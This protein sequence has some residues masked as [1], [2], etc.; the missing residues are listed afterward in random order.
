[1]RGMWSVWE[2]SE[3]IRGKDCLGVAGDA[4]ILKLNLN[5]NMKQ[6]F[7]I[8][9]ATP[10]TELPA[11]LDIWVTNTPFVKML[12]PQKNYF[13]LYFCKNITCLYVGVR[14]NCQIFFCTL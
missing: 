13:S 11:L 6:Q 2:M 12:Y 14:S 1:M 5:R 9:H 7:V 3:N 4:M 10:Q 8:T